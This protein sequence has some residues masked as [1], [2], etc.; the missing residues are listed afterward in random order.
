MN[1]TNRPMIFVNLAVRDLPASMTF[2]SKLGFEYNRK[3]CDDNAACMIIN[4]QA[5]VMLLREPFFKTFTDREICD[6]KTHTE[7]L[8]AISCDGR[9]KVDELV[10]K[11]MAAGGS[12]ARDPVDHGFMYAWSFYDLDGHHWEVLWMDPAAATA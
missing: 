6:T 8:F 4:E 9:E 1:S 5:F 11:A 3:F 12:R 7:G 2:F 10:H